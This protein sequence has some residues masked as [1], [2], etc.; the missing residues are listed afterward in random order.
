MRD[1]IYL[2]KGFSGRNKFFDKPEHLALRKKWSF[3]L[4]IFS[5][6]ETKSAENYGFGDQCWRNP[7]WK[8]SFF[9]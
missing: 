7:S 9:V 1:G 2:H 3:P 5:V 8:T 6:N 4:R